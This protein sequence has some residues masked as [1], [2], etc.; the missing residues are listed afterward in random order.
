MLRLLRLRQSLRL[1]FRAS[2]NHV[3][4]PQPTVIRVQPVRFRR[5]N[6]LS[7]TLVMG[8]TATLALYVVLT[9]TQLIFEDDEDDD[10]DD[11]SEGDGPDDQEFE[12]DLQSFFFIPF[13]G[14]TQM[15]EPP[16]YRSTDPEWRVY[17]QINRDRELQDSIRAS[18]AQVALNA[19]VKHPLLV[20]QFGKDAKIF[21]YWLEVY[22]PLKP[23]PTF[24]RQGLSWSG[25]EGLIWAEQQVDPDAVFRTRS[26][27]W[28]LPLATALWKFSGALAMQNVMTIARYFGYESREDSL[29]NMQGAIDRV[30]Q[31]LKQQSEKSGSASPS[32]PQNQANGASTTGSLPRVEGGS[33]GS[34]TTPET[35]GP[36]AGVGRALPTTPSAKDIY[37]VRTTQEHASGPWDSFKKTLKEKWQ[38]IPAYPPRGSIRVS[39]LVS[40]HTPGAILTVD[41]VGWWDPQT[42]KFDPRTTSLK[43]RTVRPRIQTP[44]R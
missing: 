4:P 27:L 5:R 21:Q 20:K 30:H 24:F 42:R 13:P 25:G 14:F 38:P 28:P 29:A 35:I 22:F 39:G 18:L 10:V 37:L 9:Q 3:N 12:E 7:S 36:G 16:P 40:I 34:T 2:S 33:G 31:R 11:E 23:P 26:A 8:A 44:L 43:L 6:N 32:P 19:I 1:P 41:C 15:I 17:L